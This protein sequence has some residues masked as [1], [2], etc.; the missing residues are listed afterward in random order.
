MHEKPSS[1][2]TV[3]RQFRVAVIVVAVLSI[4]SGIVH[5]WLDARW[6]FANDRLS[7]AGRLEKLPEHIEDWVMVQDNEISEQVQNLLRCDGYS[8]RVYANEETGE[9]VAMA[10]LYGPRGPTAVHN[11]EICYEGA[12]LVAE[13]EA[14]RISVGG[15]AD[16]LWKVTMLDE[17]DCNAQQRFIT[18][19]ATEG[20]GQRPTTPG[21]GRQTDSIRFSLPDNRRPPARRLPSRTPEQ[22]FTRSQKVDRWQLIRLRSFARS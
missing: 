10:I 15:S 8:N 22:V 5:G 6:S 19:G 12:G 1:F 7:I 17:L 2:L 13:A 14:Q 21:F 18:R 9:Q 20:H 16:T 4:A 11:P 3:G